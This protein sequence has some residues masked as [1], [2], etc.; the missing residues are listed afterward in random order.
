MNK[1]YGIKFGYAFL[2]F[3][4]H[5]SRSLSIVPYWCN[6]NS[7]TTLHFNMVNAD[8]DNIFL[9]IVKMQVYYINH[10]IDKNQIITKHQTDIDVKMEPLTRL[11]INTRLKSKI[12]CD[13]YVKKLAVDII[14]HYA[15]GNPENGQ[16]RTCL[17]IPPF[18]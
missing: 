2:L 7:T 12:E 6:A 16:V 17:C 18:N 10:Y 4:P 14:A 11:I 15:L 9:A 3:F 1:L 8:P 5:F 13:E